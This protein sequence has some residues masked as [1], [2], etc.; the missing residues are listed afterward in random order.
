MGKPLYMNY[1]RR[2]KLKNKKFISLSHKPKPYTLKFKN[3]NLL[4]LGLC[5]FNLF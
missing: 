2:I 1:V 4:S 5:F 3:T